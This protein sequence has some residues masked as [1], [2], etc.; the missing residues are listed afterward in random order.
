MRSEAQIRKQVEARFRRWSLLVLNGI[1]WVGAAKLI[2]V[3]SQ[4]HSFPSRADDVG[5]LF[6]VGWLVLFGLH[7][8]RTV[9]V[10][11]REYLVR[12]AVERERASFELHDAYEKR[13]HDQAPRR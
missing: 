9:Y 5:I 13:K 2:Y 1:L 11:M 10:E 3:F 7:F 12:R 4:S 8:L 6:M